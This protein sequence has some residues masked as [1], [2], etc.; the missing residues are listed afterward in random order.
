MKKSSDLV[1][2]RW[3]GWH[4]DLRKWNPINHSLRT[5]RTAR[6]P[7]GDVNCL[8]GGRLPVASWGTTGNWQVHPVLCLSTSCLGCYQTRQN[9][10]VK[11]LRQTFETSGSEGMSDWSGSNNGLWNSTVIV[12]GGISCW[13]RPKLNKKSNLWCPY[14]HRC[15]PPKHCRDRLLVLLTWETGTSVCQSF[16]V[17]VAQWTRKQLPSFVSFLI[18]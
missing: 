9:S 11:N 18:I 1:C 15:L 2:Q 8:E 4:L 14:S 13:Y 7:S 5:S 17:G 12:I 10:C 3:G 6:A 16:S